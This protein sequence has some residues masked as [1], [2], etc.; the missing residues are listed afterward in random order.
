MFVFF[1][2]LVLLA[3]AFGVLWA[4]IKVAVFVVLT[5]ITVAALLGLTGY[6][7]FKWQVGKIAKTLERRLQ[8]PGV[9][10]RY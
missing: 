2:F 6:L 9:D 1:L 7:V 8:P 3:I 10:D 4:V 5:V